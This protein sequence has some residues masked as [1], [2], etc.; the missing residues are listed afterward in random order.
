LA[1]IGLLS[2]F[3]VICNRQAGRIFPAG[4]PAQLVSGLGREDCP[5]FA[6]L[7]RK[8]GSQ[9]SE[10]VPNLENWE[11]RKKGRKKEGFY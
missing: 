9:K 6:Y 3:S 4:C 5:K 2:S 8:G 7:D 1:G 10:M 11:K